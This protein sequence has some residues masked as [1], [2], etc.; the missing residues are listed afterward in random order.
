VACRTASDQTPVSGRSA[1]ALPGGQRRSPSR[2]RAKARPAAGKEFKSS[3]QLSFVLSRAVYSLLL[4]LCTTG[5]LLPWMGVG[6][7][8]YAYA[9]WTLPTSFPYAIGLLIGFVVLV[10]GREPVELTA[11]AG[12]LM[13]IGILLTMLG[14]A[15]MAPLAREYH[16]TSPYLDTGVVLA[17]LSTVLFIA[18]GPFV[19]ENFKRYWRLA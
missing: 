5:Y 4:L 1:R 8:G 3:T 15:V 19:G 18:V 7:N 6:E 11:V 13:L 9:G 16:L 10:T 12:V 14:A 2:A 17:A